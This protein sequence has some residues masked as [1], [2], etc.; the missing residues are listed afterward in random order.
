MSHIQFN[1]DKERM[2]IDV[3]YNEGSNESRDCLELIECL[4]YARHRQWL[5][6][7]QHQ[8]HLQYISSALR[9]NNFTSSAHLHFCSFYPT[10]SHLSTPLLMIESKQGGRVRGCSG[11]SVF[12]S[13]FNCVNELIITLCVHSTDFIDISCLWKLHVVNFSCLKYVFWVMWVLFLT[14]YI[15]FSVLFTVW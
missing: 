11:N 12:I 10:P 3:R 7:L 15:L 1:N 8:A 5:M 9:K 2:W 14:L 6:F 4:P 13:Y